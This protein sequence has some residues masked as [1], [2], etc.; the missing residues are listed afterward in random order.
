MLPK[1]KLLLI[2]RNLNNVTK[3]Y[4]NL[5]LDGS[6]YF[7]K[8]LD[9]AI[10]SLENY[11]PD[12]IYRFI[13]VPLAL[14]PRAG[15]EN[16]SKELHDVIKI[17]IKEG[18]IQKETIIEMWSIKFNVNLLGIISRKNTDYLKNELDSFFNAQRWKRSAHSSL[19]VDADVELKLDRDYLIKET[20]WRTKNIKISYPNSY[21]A[22]WAVLDMITPFKVGTELTFY[23]DKLPEKNWNYTASISLI[24]DGMLRKYLMPIIHFGSK[25]E[26]TKLIVDLI[27]NSEDLNIGTNQRIYFYRKKKQD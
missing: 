7:D 21:T 22:G 14:E 23:S 24:Y 20:A 5:K 8:Y 13:S 4:P 17:K 9:S 25:E 1:K 19:F 12:T 18:N 15:Y 6:I 2:E 27:S 11:R 10:V 3:K 26:T 16:F